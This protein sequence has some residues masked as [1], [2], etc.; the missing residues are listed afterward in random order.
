MRIDMSVS[1]HLLTID[2]SYVYRSYAGCYEG[3]PSAA[4][5]VESA[6]QKAQEMWG[7]RPTLVLEPQ[8]KGK[9]VPKYTYMVWINGPALTEDGDG[10]ELVVIWWS[11]MTPDT[12]RVF[13]A[14]D[15]EKHAKD[16]QI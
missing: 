13:K 1:P 10:S 15:W 16:F 14:I 7:S 4:V 3:A 9:M 12:D 8:L 11:E 2:A 5:M 6:K